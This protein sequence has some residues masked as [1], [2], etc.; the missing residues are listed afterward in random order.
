MGKTLGQVVR[1]RRRDLGYT[2][3]ELA[4]RVGDGIGQADISRIENDRVDLPRRSR[5]ERLARA[6]DLPLGSLLIHAGWSDAPREVAELTVT[7][8][9]RTELERDA[10][11]DAAPVLEDLA[12]AVGQMHELVHQAETILGGDDPGPVRDEP[13][14]GSS[15]TSPTR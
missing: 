15:A 13:A 5:L 11:E 3:E 10:G 14:P 12:E 6:L 7:A 4:L 9:V 8:M 2:Q 1:A